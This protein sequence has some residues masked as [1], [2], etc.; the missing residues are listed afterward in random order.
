MAF[1]KLAVPASDFCSRFLPISR[2]ERSCWHISHTGGSCNPS[3]GRFRTY[4]ASVKPVSL[5]SC[6]CFLVLVRF[7]PSFL[8]LYVLLPHMETSTFEFYSFYTHGTFFAAL[9][10]AGCTVLH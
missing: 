10:S 8:F 7:F 9:C 4:W 2:V 3:E 6:A 1:R 5:A